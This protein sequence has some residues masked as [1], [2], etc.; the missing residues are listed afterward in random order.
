MK[1]LRILAACWLFAVFTNEANS[2]SPR[3]SLLFKDSLIG[4]DYGPDCEGWTIN[5]GR[6]AGSSNT[7]PL[8]SGWS[9]GDF[10][11]EIVWSAP[12]GSG[13]QLAFP[14][15]PDEKNTWQVELVN[16]AYCGQ[17]RLRSG[18]TQ[19]TLADGAALNGDES[20][21]HRARIV[22]AGARLTV[23]FGDGLQSEAAIAAD[24]R[25]GLL[26]AAFGKQ[27]TI[28]SLAVREPAGE[29]IFNEQD[30]SGWWTPGNLDAWQVEGNE[31]VKRGGG[32]NYLR[33][34]KEYGNFTL[35]F[36]YK[37]SKGGNS[38]VGIRTKPNGWPSGDGME[39]QLYDRES[40]DKSSTMAIYRNFAPL[41]IAHRS[42]DWNQAVIKAD[43]YMV[44]AWVNGQLVQ[45]ANTLRHPE[46]KYR[47]LSGWIGFQDHGGVDQFRNIRVLEAP[48][49][50]GGLDRWY[51][52]RGPTAAELVLDRLM[53]QQSLARA[54]GVS[55]HFVAAT[56]SGQKNQTLAEFSGAGALVRIGYDRGDTKLALYFDGEAKPRVQCKAAELAARLPR[57]TGVGQPCLTC[58]AFAKGLR[59]VAEEARE[60]ATFDFA[61]AALPSEVLLETFRDSTKSSPPGWL[62]TIDYRHHHHRFGTHR[63]A[64]PLPRQQSANAKI[65]P[66]SAVP[67]LQVDGAGIVQWLKLHGTKENL[68][69][70]DD[71][72]LAIT[73]DGEASPAIFAPARY[74]YAMIQDGQNYP[75]FVMLHSGGF[76]SRLAMP[77]AGGF[78]VVAHNRGDEAIGP[79]GAS[80]SFRREVDAQA[81]AGW[82]RLRGVFDAD[83]K[84]YSPQQVQINGGGRIVAL[85]AEN[86][87][88]QEMGIQSCRLDG[89]ACDGLSDLSAERILGLPK[90]KN[91]KRG[92][93]SGVGQGLAWRYFLL[94]PIDFQTNAAITFAGK[95]DAKHLVL[96][97]A[98]AEK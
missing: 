3:Q 26:L 21:T 90:G 77:F 86:K 89:H 83:D 48:D 91:P 43:G 22:R 4:W 44:S 7:S 41:A 79:V 96:Y 40:I 52:E 93:L 37:I 42:E 36:E 75:N 28:T 18:G 65:E 13:A 54:D 30:L 9:F 66:G 58:A 10:D 92:Y 88:G 34:K 19:Q 15:L 80:I 25:C 24:A 35:S 20:Q 2:E 81:M 74:L 63:E 27:V 49:G 39:L 76:A 72:W 62:A 33:T 69:A 56:A 8:V 53:N 50:R 70:N 60:G 95:P 71:L 12:A 94:A 6:L 85:V 16:G 59:I 57:L 55:T 64:D 68:L 97:Y 47:H 82:A 32:G 31:L 17:I 98:T 46:L 5:D 84:E 87:S 29:R 45:H 11:L 73:V 14:Q 61:W 51:A 23:E 38:G 67:L 78:S 1:C